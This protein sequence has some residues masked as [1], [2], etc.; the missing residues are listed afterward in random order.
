MLDARVLSPG[1]TGGA[2]S[3]HD[4]PVP[5]RAARNIAQLLPGRPLVGITACDGDGLEV[6]GW[7]NRLAEK[8]ELAQSRCPD[9]PG[10]EV[11]RTGH[12][13]LVGNLRVERR[14]GE[15]REQLIAYGMR[16][17]YCQPLVDDDRLLGLLTLYS[18]R[19]HAFRPRP[20]A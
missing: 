11:V 5:Q 12:A 18:A 13:I 16:S 2:G 10:L 8:L 17:L 7:S 3:E 20:E 19:E 14:W 15:F 1:S 6:L 9:T 4:S